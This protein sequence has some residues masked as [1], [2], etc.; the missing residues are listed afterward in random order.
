[1]RRG[2]M[3]KL[4]IVHKPL[5]GKQKV[6][7][8]SSPRTYWAISTKVT[9]ASVWARAATRTKKK[10][11][12]WISVLNPNNDVTGE[13]ICALTCYDVCA[14]IL[15]TTRSRVTIFFIT[16]WARRLLETNCLIGGAWRNCIQYIINKSS[17]RCKVN[18]FDPRNIH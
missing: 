18:Y 6:V 8:S 13:W 17:P 16:V 12:W 14:V 2:N 4:H 5:A 7:S 15:P 3:Y 9:F 11:W 10:I 1:M